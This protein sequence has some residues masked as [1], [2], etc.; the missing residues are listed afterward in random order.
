MKHAFS[1]LFRSV[2]GNAAARRS[3]RPL[4]VAALLGMTAALIAARAD[5]RGGAPAAVAPG[6]PIVVEIPGTAHSMTFRPVPGGAVETPRTAGDPGATERIEVAP[7]MLATTELT[8]DVLDVFVYGLDRPADDPPGADGVTRPS[9]PYL[10]MDRGFGHAGYPAISMSA[11]TAEAF[12]AWLS[13]TTG[14]RVR[15]PTE[16]EWRH[17]A[18]LAAIDPARVDEH[19]WHAGNARR[20]THPVGKKTA[21]ALGLHDLY[22]NAG[23]WCLAADGKPVLLG[24][25]YREPAS[26]LGVAGR[27]VPSEDWNA[28]DPQIPKSVWWLADGP[29]TGVRLVCEPAPAPPAD[30]DDE[31]APATRPGST[32]DR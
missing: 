10:T 17:A 4:A 25:S 3:R 29:W 11:K 9:K 6:E 5:D 16:A 21:D 24:G 30:H 14:H 28:S 22:G 12:A 15:L 18:A 32:D 2:R 7:F 31:P 20:T 23:E 27:M 1:P 26:R 13:T 8:W 19:A